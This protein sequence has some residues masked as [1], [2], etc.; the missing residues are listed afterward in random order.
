MNTYT[1]YQ[2]KQTEAASK[3]NIIIAIIGNTII[4]TR[5]VLSLFSEFGKSLKPVGF[6]IVIIFVVV[7][8]ILTQSGLVEELVVANKPDIQL[9][10]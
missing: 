5:P 9:H 8:V 6:V 2:Q 4:N 1:L 7:C 3:A 10:V